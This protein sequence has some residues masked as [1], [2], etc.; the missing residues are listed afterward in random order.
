MTSTVFCANCGKEFEPRNKR[1]KFCCVTC[2]KKYQTANAPVVTATCEHCGKEFTY[3]K[4]SKNPVRFC[5]QACGTSHIVPTKVCTCVDCGVTFEFVGRTTKKRCDT[6]RK[7]HLSKLVMESRVRMNPS[8][9]MGIGSG[10]GQNIHTYEEGSD[11]AIQRDRKNA[12][13]RERYAEHR[14]V[15]QAEE[16]YRSAVITGNDSCSVCGY[17]RHQEAL[18]VHHID[19]D[20]TNKDPNNLVII[21]ANCHSYIHRT[22]MKILKEFETVDPR[23]VYEDI[24]NAEVKLR[25]EAG[26]PTGQ[27]EPK[28]TSNDSQ[29]QSVVA[30]P[31]EDISYQEAAAR[32]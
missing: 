1:H 11:K 9:R 26:K 29:G 6:C 20:R 7:K 25:N 15:K 23:K 27:S 19:R 31:I 3:K 18:Q 28:A 21:C 17:N 22:I 2:K 14:E 4:Y 32:K 16:N 5:S 13:R 8:V 12:R 24:R 30:G 10:G